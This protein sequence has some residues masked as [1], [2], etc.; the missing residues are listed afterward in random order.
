MSVAPFL[1]P[2][3]PPSLTTSWL[4]SGIS[5]HLIHGKGDLASVRHLVSSLTSAATTQVQSLTPNSEPPTSADAAALVHA[6]CEASEPSGAARS[7][8][9]SP[10]VAVDLL[11][12]NGST[13]LLYA[14]GGGHLGVAAVLIKVWIVRRCTALYG[15]CD[16]SCSTPPD[17]WEKPVGIAPFGHTAARAFLPLPP[18]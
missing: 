18:S 7:V 17:P 11:S 2:P 8:M 6:T 10:L 12:F 9:T 14:C 3:P 1:K 16:P 15:S 4:L 13:P 5:L